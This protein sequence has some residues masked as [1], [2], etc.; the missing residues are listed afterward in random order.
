M[1]KVAVL[2]GGLIGLVFYGGFFFW[3][4]WLPFRALLLC[5]DKLKI[6]HPV[7]LFALGCTSLIVL[8]MGLNA[9]MMMMAFLPMIGPSIMGLI[10]LLFFGVVSLSGMVGWII[11][12]VKRI[13]SR[14]QVRAFNQAHPLPKT[15]FWIQDLMLAIFYFGGLMAFG[16]LVFNV[17]MKD[18]AQ[19]AVAL[20]ALYLLVASGLGFHISLDLMRRYQDKP[21]DTWPRIGILLGCLVFS[22]ISGLVGILLVWRA[23]QKALLTLAMRDEKQEATESPKTVLPVLAPGREGT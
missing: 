15:Q 9:V 3:G 6:R 2:I 16:A 14:A 19:Y 22:T 11:V 17:S 7:G 4:Y 10:G 8:Y 5:A 20:L 18:E 23:W 21:Y 13:R 12:G 1:T